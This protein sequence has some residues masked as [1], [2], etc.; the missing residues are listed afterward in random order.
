MV[1]L[2]TLVVGFS[3]C[4]SQKKLTEI[5]DFEKV[6]QSDDESTE[7]VKEEPKEIKETVAKAVSKEDRLNNYF[8]AIATASSVNSANASIQEALAMFVGFANV[9]GEPK[10]FFRPDTEHM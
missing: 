8:G 10:L 2:V 5:S 1:T 7:Q 4:K 9:F 6:A 3:S